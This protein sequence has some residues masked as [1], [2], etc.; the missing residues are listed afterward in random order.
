[1]VYGIPDLDNKTAKHVCKPQR[2]DV[3]I[4]AEKVLS[5]IEPS[6]TA[7][8]IDS[9]RSHGLKVLQISVQDQ[10]VMPGLID[11][12]VHAIGGGGEQGLFVYL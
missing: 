7:S 9:T 8:F 1:M 6:K 3:I 2:V 11:V 4:A 12:H 5:L 10:I